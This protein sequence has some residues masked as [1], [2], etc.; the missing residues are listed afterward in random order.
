MRP[1]ELE[2]RRQ[3]ASREHRHL[4]A[5]VASPLPADLDEKGYVDPCDSQYCIVPSFGQR[6]TL[7]AKARDISVRQ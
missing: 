6:R 4:S 3:L 2:D 5:K 1:I 7:A